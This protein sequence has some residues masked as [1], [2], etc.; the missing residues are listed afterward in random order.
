MQRGPRPAQ[1]PCIDEFY[2]TNVHY[3]PGSKRFFVVS[4]ARNQLW[5]NNEESNPGGKFDAFVRRYFA[6]AVSR[7]EDPRD[8]FHQYL[9]VEHNYFDFPWLAVTGNAVLVS[10]VNVDANDNSLRA[11][12]VLSVSDVTKGVVDPRRY[13]LW[14]TDLGGTPGYRPV[15]TFGDTGGLA[16]LFHPS[17]TTGTYEL[18]GLPSTS[19]GRSAPAALQVSFK[20][21]EPLSCGKMSD[22]MYRNGK[23]YLVNCTVVG[24]AT[25]SQIARYSV[26]VLR[27]PIQ[28]TGS[29]LTASMAQADGFLDRY[30]GRNAQSDSPNDLVSY[31]R[32]AIA[33]NKSED[34]IL[35][36]GRVGVATA[37]P[38]KQEVRYSIWPAG[39]EAP[40]RSQ[41]LMPG[42]SVVQSGGKML[43]YPG[44]GVDYGMAAVDSS[45]DETFW[46]TH[47]VGDAGGSNLRQV[48]IGRVR[49]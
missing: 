37:L 17:S 34:M 10:H 46:V 40:L 43:S 5:F 39:A 9:V 11:G 33:V 29:T 47:M 16:F 13:R 26:R 49:P 7:G 22:V 20:L 48:V 36:Y 32:P 35:V 23:L 24:S 30:F 19:V 41:L 44:G 27:I 3:D 42:Q 18:F 15:T 2:D 6:V 8:G 1:F 38:L 4:A 28:T 14:R 31:E 45:D 12:Y 21:S 25:S